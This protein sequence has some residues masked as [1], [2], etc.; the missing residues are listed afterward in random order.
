[1]TTG[2]LGRVADRGRWLLLAPEGRMTLAVVYC[3][4]AAISI[5]TYAIV[6]SPLYGAGQL[7]LTGLG[8][9]WALWC[10]RR[11]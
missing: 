5:V 1:M 3:I 9:R 10:L 2:I 4:A 8:L 11:T 7:V 6:R